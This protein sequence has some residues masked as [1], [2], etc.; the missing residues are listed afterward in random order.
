MD[1]TAVE[2]SIEILFGTRVLN[3]IPWLSDRS[4]VFIYLDFEE[5]WTL[6]LINLRRPYN[7]TEMTEVTS[8]GAERNVR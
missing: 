7:G 5:R 6:F 2:R 4:T 3:E 8:A 1:L